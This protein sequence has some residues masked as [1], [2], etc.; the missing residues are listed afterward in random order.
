[1]LRSKMEVDG[2]RSSAI[3]QI[4]GQSYRSGGRWNLC[5]VHSHYETPPVV[6]CIVQFIAYRLSKLAHSTLSMY[7]LLPFGSV[8]LPCSV[9]TKAPRSTFHTCQRALIR[10]ISISP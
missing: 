4:D 8:T 3:G 5:H 2:E 10:T 7:Q 1:M 9:G 6:A